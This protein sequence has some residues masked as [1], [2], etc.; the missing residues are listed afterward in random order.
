SIMSISR[1][2]LL[3]AVFSVCITGISL[4]QPAPQP[5]QPA[6]AGGTLEPQGGA[7]GAGAPGRGGAR[8]GAPGGAGA[9]GGAIPDDYR[10]GAD[11]STAPAGFD[12]KRDNIEAGKLERVDYDAPAV[13]PGLK[14]WMEVYT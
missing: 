3:G 7:G 5:A 1:V 4:A 13:A 6:P 11:T 10:T 12:K 2:S 9:R 14:R 8:G